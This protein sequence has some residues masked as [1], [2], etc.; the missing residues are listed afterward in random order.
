M[1]SCFCYFQAR[2]L[3]PRKPY[4]IGLTG[5]IASGKSS[6]GQRLVKL[7]AG[8]VNCDTLAHSVYMR[9]KPCYDAIVQHFGNEIL[10]DDGEINR[11]ALGAVVFNSKVLELV[12]YSQTLY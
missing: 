11:K 10:G 1:S 12:Y 3:L 7:G 5:N 2:P 9:G 8:L 4:I 6:V